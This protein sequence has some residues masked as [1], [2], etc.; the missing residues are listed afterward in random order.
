MLV[1]KTFIFE[2]TRIFLIDLRTEYSGQN[3]NMHYTMRDTEALILQT[4]CQG[5]FNVK[6]SIVHEY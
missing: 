5:P 2:V 1:Q 4:S 3:V 6:C